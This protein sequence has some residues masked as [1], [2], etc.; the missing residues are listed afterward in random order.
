M[1]EYKGR[2]TAELERNGAAVRLMPLDLADPA[3]I[4]RFADDVRAHEGSIHGLINNGI[5][6]LPDPGGVGRSAII[7]DQGRQLSFAAMWLPRI[8]V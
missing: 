2:Q 3:A 7:P 4:E 1:L 5:T 8:S 6:D